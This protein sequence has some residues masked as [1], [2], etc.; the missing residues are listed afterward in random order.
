LNSRKNSNI[1]N[2]SLILF[3]GLEMKICRSAK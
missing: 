2:R 1:N 3:A